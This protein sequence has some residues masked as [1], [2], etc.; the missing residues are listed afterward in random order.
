LKEPGKRQTPS[1]EQDLIAA[2]QHGDTGAFQ[3]LY[4]YY[5]ERVY[6]LIYYSLNDVQQAEDAFQTVFVK[7]F[8]ALPHF[9]LESSFHT[10]MYRIALNEC[11]NRKRRPRLFVP[12]SNISDGRDE[13]DPSP[14]PDA[15]HA[16]NQSAQIVR[17][18]VMNLK[19]KYRTVVILKYLEEMSYE[20]I[21]VTLGCS[22]GTVASRLCRALQ[23]LE[24]R[25][26]GAY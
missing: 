23:I 6:N 8:K 14:G 21:A 24:K 16:S 17:R 19:P 11:K 13:P 10:W 20:E 25:L 5:R 7:V 22:P 18:A 9:R 26:G 3:E 2:A 15:L 4:E 12:I 1:G